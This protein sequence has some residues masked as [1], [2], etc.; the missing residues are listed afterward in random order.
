MRFGLTA[1]LFC[2]VLAVNM[3]VVI[4]TAMATRVSFDRDFIRYLDEQEMQRAERAVPTLAAEYQAH[5]GWNFLA[6]NWTAWL[7]ILHSTQDSVPAGAENDS[8]PAAT[9]MRFALIDARDNYVVGNSEPTDRSLR[10]PITVNGQLAGWLTMVC[11]RDLVRVGDI[12]FQEKRTQ[13]SWIIAGVTSLLAAAIA[14]WLARALAA[15]LRRLAGATHRL[16][17]GDYVARVPV[18]SGGDIGQLETDFNQLAATLADNER[19]RRHFVADVS[20]ELRTPLA[21][22]QGEIEAVND[23]VRPIDACAVASLQVEVRRLNKLVDDLHTLSLSELDTLRYQWDDVDFAASIRHALGLYQARFASAEVAVSATGLF[24]SVHVH[25]D[26]DRIQQVLQN[27]LEN[28]VRYVDPGQ[29]I[30]LRLH[31]VGDD[32]VLDIQDS[33]SGV[34]DDALPRLFERFYRVEGSRNRATGGSGLGLPVCRSIVEAH[35]G[36]ITASNA[37]QGGLWIR[38]FLPLMVTTP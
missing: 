31:I 25:A 5:H 18:V 14:L 4:A 34:P 3:A 36:H 17:R 29:S 16:A 35:G 1:K 23:G 26:E 7:R 11:M 20:H 13:T 15:P 8:D 30:V 37:P 6:K 28:T 22:M 19:T 32:A 12:R 24:S 27:L 21:I 38:M 10:R 2:A 33:G 9:N